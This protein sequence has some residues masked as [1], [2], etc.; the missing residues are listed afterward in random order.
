MIRNR[1]QSH[2]SLTAILP[3]RE[4]NFILPF[5][6]D[7][8]IENALHTLTFAFQMGI[9]AERAIE[10]IGSIEPVSMR[11]EMLQGIQGS[12]LINDAYNS[13][14][15]GLS[16]A[17]DLV[18][19]QDKRNGKV[20]ILSDLLQSGLADQA[21]Y[22][23]IAALIS[24]KGIDLFI[25]IGPAIMQHRALFPDTALFYKD[26]PEFL[27]RMDRTLFRDRVILIKGSRKFGFEQNH[28]RTAAEN[29][30]DPAGD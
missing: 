25:G 2:T 23:E 26:T 5:S 3:S 9:P 16:A 6:D 8:S 1:V 13:D 29:T 24:R 7:A 4:L 27:R 14:T 21:L 19:Q 15:G 28:R 11:L 17:L 22:T 30:P 20:I 12:V 10:R 18:A